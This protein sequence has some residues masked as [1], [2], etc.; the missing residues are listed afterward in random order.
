MCFLSRRGVVDHRLDHVF[1]VQAG[2]HRLSWITGLTMCFL[3]R[4]GVVDHRLDHVFLV[5][6]GCRGVFHIIATICSPARIRC[7]A[8]QFICLFGF[9]QCPHECCEDFVS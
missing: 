4:R 8:S 9:T 7:A 2:D 6:A 5:Q 3:S 1:L